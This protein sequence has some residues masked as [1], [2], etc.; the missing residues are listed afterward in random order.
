[1]LISFDSLS[2]LC[3]LS[4]LFS[5]VCSV[6]LPRLLLFSSSP[7]VRLLLLFCLSQI[8]PNYIQMLISFHVKGKVTGM[9]HF[10]T[11]AINLG[12]NIAPWMSSPPASGLAVGSNS[13]APHSIISHKAPS[14]TI[15]H[16]LAASEPPAIAP[17]PIRKSSLSSSR[18]PS[19]SSLL[20]A[21]NA[22]IS[23]SSSSA[24]SSGLAPAAEFNSVSAP[25]DIQNP[26]RSSSFST[27]SAS[28]SSPSSSSCLWHAEDLTTQYFPDADDTPVVVGTRIRASLSIDGTT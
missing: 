10:G 25:P 4:L 26:R 3:I 2:P 19:F 1:M 24:F 9:D 13:S 11:T 28:A 18:Y 12:R 14:T 15:P 7:F 5:S 6:L 8:A 16:S 21:A 17:I 27:P 20:S 23:S 22:V